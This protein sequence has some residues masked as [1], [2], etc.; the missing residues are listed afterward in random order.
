[1]PNLQ[2]LSAPRRAPRLPRDHFAARPPAPISKVQRVIRAIT[3]LAI[4]GYCIA[5]W[6]RH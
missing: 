6:L 2:I 1:M 4:I 3:A 5:L